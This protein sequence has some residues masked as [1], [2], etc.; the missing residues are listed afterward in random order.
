MEK[1]F[2][3]DRQEFL[4]KLTELLRLTRN[5]GGDGNPLREIRLI[6]KPTGD[7]A[8]P[9]FEDGNGENGYYDINITCDSNMG[10]LK[11]VMNHFI[12]KVW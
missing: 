8:R 11:D 3:E 10:I 6:E 2:A 1:R 4:N 9:I 12:T 7:Y 5:A